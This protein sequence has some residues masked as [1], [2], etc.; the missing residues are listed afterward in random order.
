MARAGTARRPAPT[1][2]RCAWSA[3]AGMR[4]A[5][6]LPVGTLGASR[7]GN[8]HPAAGGLTNWCLTMNHDC[9]IMDYAR[10]NRTMIG[11]ARFAF[12][13]P[14]T[15]TNQIVGYS[16]RHYHQGTAHRYGCARN[17]CLAWQRRPDDMA[18]AMF[19]SPAPQ[20]A[21]RHCANS[22]ALL[23]TGKE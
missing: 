23:T 9:A 15:I 21:K 20:D 12:I 13:A 4:L 6:S 16:A 2:R 11:R 17:G 8:A 19:L 7:R 10:L 22:D 3:G 5:P 14:S 18:G 1:R